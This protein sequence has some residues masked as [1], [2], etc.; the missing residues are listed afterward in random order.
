MD[1]LRCRYVVA[2]AVLLG[3]SLPGLAAESIAGQ[4][5][6]ALSGNPL[7]RVTLTASRVDGKG[8]P[9]TAQVD[10]NG[11]F[12]FR[13]LA[14]GG[15][16]LSGE[17]NGFDRQFH[18]ARS[19]PNTGAVLPVKE[20]QPIAGLVFRLFPNT[21]I[22]GRVLEAEGEPLP[23]VFV[24]VYRREYRNGKRGWYPLSGTQTTDRG[25]YR[26]SGLR[27]GRYLV[28]ATEFNF[29]IAL[30][31]SKGPLLEAPDRINASTYY[32][33]T[34]EFQSAEPVAL[35]RGEDRRGVDIQLVKG[36]A[37]R[38]RGR[39]AGAA[40]STMLVVNL[41]PKSAP[42]SPSTGGG[43]A[44]VQ[45]GERAFEIRGVRPGAYILVARSMDG[46]SAVS[47][48]VPVDVG[49][50]HIEGVEL[51]LSEGGEVAGRILFDGGAKGA[52]VT[53]EIPDAS[54]MSA[55]S[56]TAN[57]AG[58]FKLRGVF[59]IQYRLR[60]ANLPEN[61]YLKAVKLAGQVVDPESVEFSPASG[62]KLEILLGKASAEL[63]G[64]VQGL[65]AKP[66]P[67]ATVVLIPES[68]RDALYRTATSDY[69]GTFL[70]KGV[71]PGRYKVLAWEDLEPD[72]YRDAEV[73]K[74]VEDRAARVA[75]E[76][77]GRV[78]VTLKVIPIAKD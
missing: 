12:V 30:A 21:V 59:P 39:I 20:G 60:T 19:N 46:F 22:S 25:E 29:A 35:A 72:A 70:L 10:E 61:T 48:P 24:R 18:G 52:S 27:A 63:K 13:N 4:V 15:Y 32:P 5:V 56:G 54:W 11:Q 33:G 73:V 6:H 78:E 34:I 65:D 69:D 37:V 28:N 75:L 38:I 43:A 47:A 64:I 57:E 26:L 76:E 14:A 42:L 16:L 1:L 17:R 7:R 45:P 62:A 23:N 74:P 58:E 53:L 44:V 3:Y 31:S 50:H 55:V 51:P 68:G 36:V 9:A 2:V 67:G 40:V 77:N 66:V 49:E 41:L 8:E 71:A